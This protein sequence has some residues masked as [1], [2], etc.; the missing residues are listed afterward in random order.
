MPR[1]L[2]VYLSACPVS[3]LILSPLSVCLSVCLPAFLPS[4]PSVLS[5]H[6]F[7]R[8]PACLTPCHRRRANTPP[9]HLPRQE[10][11]TKAEFGASVSVPEEAEQQDEEGGTEQLALESD[12]PEREVSQPHQKI[13]HPVSAKY[14]Y[15]VSDG[16]WRVCKTSPSSRSRRTA[17]RVSYARTFRFS[18]TRNVKT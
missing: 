7:V 8:L 17:P 12:R 6:P 13:N 18:M 10:M 3:L 14:T 9:L 1:Q 4:L 5:V 11:A 15:V 16:L 2:P